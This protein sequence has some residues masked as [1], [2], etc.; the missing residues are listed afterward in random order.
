MPPTDTRSRERRSELL[1]R[2]ESRC[3]S[4]GGVEKTSASE[5]ECRNLRHGRRDPCI[6]ERRNPDDVATIEAVVQR[7]DST[8]GRGTRRPG[9]AASPVRVIGEIRIIR[10][11]GTRR[12]SDLLSHLVQAR[13][14]HRSVSTIA[15]RCRSCLATDATWRDYEWICFHRSVYRRIAAVSRRGSRCVVCGSRCSSR[16]AASDQYAKRGAFDESEFPD[17]KDIYEVAAATSTATSICRCTRCA[18]SSAPTTAAS[19]DGDDLEVVH[20]WRHDIGSGG[21]EL[22]HH[23]IRSRRPIRETEDTL[24]HRRPDSTQMLN[25]C[26]LLVLAR[27]R[28]FPPPTSMR[29]T[30]SLI[31]LRNT[32][33]DVL[34]VI[35]GTSRSQIR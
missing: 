26:A 13:I 19:A 3:A 2:L 17:G 5:C 14:H 7:A 33:T 28:Q 23:Q 35:A 34:G 30:S 6:S 11:V 1:E 20:A 18:A 16:R 4:S 31:S 27:S 9:R 32:A 10:Q 25:V 22:R 29:P 12:R 24:V 15:S 8:A 21:L